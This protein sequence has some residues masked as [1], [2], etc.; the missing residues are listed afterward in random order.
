M[1]L[2]TSAPAAIK[3]NAVVLGVDLG[4]KVDPSAIVVVEVLRRP[5]GRTVAALRSYQGAFYQTP[6]PGTET[7]F[8]C[9][10]MERLPLGTSYRDVAQRVVQVAKNIQIRSAYSA[11]ISVVVDVTG[12]GTPP[13]ESV[14]HALHGTRV[15]PIAATFTHGD[16]LSANPARTELRVG[17]AYLVS[18]MQT[19]IEHDRL[20]LPPNHAEAA[21]MARE[22]RDY[23]IKVDQDGND[24]YGAFKVGSHDD[25]VTALGLAVLT[26]PPG[27]QVWSC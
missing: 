5:S 1:G 9:R 13:F 14:V 17:K 16:K 26:D 15:R 24:K 23:E 27:R 7:V 6:V 22:L 25:Y 8:E 2:V 11:G 20:S 18:R 3:T 19:L 10:F 21:A 4:Q 12:V